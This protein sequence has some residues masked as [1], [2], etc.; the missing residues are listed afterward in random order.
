[1]KRTTLLVGAATL[2][3]GIAAG[4]LWAQQQPQGPQP[5]FVG[6]RLGLPINPA[7]DGDL[8]ADLL[9]RE[10]LRRH[11]LSRE[12]LVRRR[13]RRHRRAESRRPAERSD[14]QRLGIVHQ[15]RWVGAHRPLAR[16]P[17]SRR[18]ALEPHA[19][20]R[21]ERAVRQRHRQR[22]ALCG[23]SRRRHD[24]DRAVG[25][26]HSPLQPARPARLPA[27]PASRNPP[28]STTS[29]L[30]TTGRSTRRR[31]ASAVRRPIP[32][33]G[34][35]GRSPATAPSSIFLQG[36]PLRQPNGIAFDPQG[37]IVVVNIGNNEVLTFSPAGQLAE[38]RE[39]G[40]GRQRRPRD[41]AGRHQVREQRA[42]RRRVAHSCR[43]A[44]GADRP[45]HPE[46]GVD[47]LR[48]G[49]QAAGDSDESQQRPGVRAAE[50]GP[51]ITRQATDHT[52]NT[53]KP[54]PCAP[55]NPWLRKPVPEL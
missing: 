51:R 27:R 36:A 12:L 28:G 2:L 35:C 33:A 26:R 18:A 45:E 44:R 32:R 30:P 25:R 15:P 37:N 53:D 19:A 3:I 50:L 34:R 23:R 43:S 29:K 41:H 11:L 9:E 49:G 24:A 5:F 14:Q 13:A 48:R 31:P 39:R 1:M 8:R 40:A 10:G 52:D 17:E 4:A 21:P 20:A 55:C 6:N 38:D 46:R 22:H 42:E 7:A 47:V 16:R 54:K